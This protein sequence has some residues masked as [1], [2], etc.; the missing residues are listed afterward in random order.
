MSEIIYE[1]FVEIHNTKDAEA[2]IPILSK[3]IQPNSVLDIGCGTG[4]W[5]KVFQDK[6]IN[7]IVGVDGSNLDKSR[8]AIPL[9]HF[10]QHNLMQPLNLKRKFDLVI[11][12]EVAEH[13]PAESA[14][15]II[16]TLIAHSDNI[17]F[18]AALPMQGGQ[19]HLNEQPFEYWVEKFNSRGYI[20]K[21]I[22]R[23]L[24]WNNSNIGWWYRQNMFLVSKTNELK[25]KKINDYYHP[26]AYAGI[27]HYNEYFKK[28]LLNI[29]KGEIPVLSAL[30]ILIKAFLVKFKLR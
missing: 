11:C 21:D 16:D 2:F 6:G 5:L 7:D 20:V 8:L 3:Y 22:F 27:A 9:N 28:Q 10:I 23:D 30:K 26:E 17:L 19:N 13:L 4:T 12:L 24:I 1:H 14:D 18:S 25:Q 29:H 15:N